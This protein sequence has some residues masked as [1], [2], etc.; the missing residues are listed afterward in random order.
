MREGLTS[1]KFNYIVLLRTK[2]MRYIKYILLLLL[3]AFPR[4]LKGEKS[5]IEKKE[6]EVEEEDT[7]E[8]ITPPSTIEKMFN[9]R[10]LLTTET[11]NQFGYDMF[12]RTIAPLAPFF[13]IA[14]E[15]VLG[16]GDQ[17]IIEISGEVNQSWNKWIGRDG[18]I[19][20]PK[21]GSIKLWGKT[22]KEAKEIIEERL[23]EEFYGI[24]VNVTLGE[25]RSVNVYV[26]GEVNKPGLYN[27]SSLSDLLSALFWAQ[28]PKKSGSL[29]RI[30]YISSKGEKLTLDLYKLLIEG[31][32][33]PE[34][35]LE[36]GDIIY[37]PP[38]G[39]VIGVTGA[40]NRPSIYEITKL[41]SVSEI[42]HVAGEMLPT[43][44]TF[45][46]QLERISKGERRV[47]EDFT[48]RDE[49][50]FKKKTE[51]IKIKNGDL[52]R[53]FEVPPYVHDYVTIEGNVEK[54][55]VYGLK[56]GMDVLELI[57]R[58]GGFLEGT[59]LKRSELLRFKGVE[60][61]EIIEID[62]E[63]LIDGDTTENIRLEEWDRL[64]IYN[65]DEIQ[66]RFTV[67]ITGEVVNPGRYPLYPNMTVDDLLFK[68]IPKRSAAQ[69]VL[70]SRIDPDGA[71]IRKTIDRDDS[72][73]CALYLEHYDEITVNKKEKYPKVGHV[74]FSGEFKRPGKYFIRDGELLVDVINIAGGFTEEAY[75]EAVVFAKKRV[76]KKQMKALLKLTQET[77]MDIISEQSRLLSADVSAEERSRLMAHFKKLLLQLDELMKLETP[78]RVVI[79]LTE[80]L[81]LNVPLGDGD[82]LFVPKKPSTVEV[83]GSVY[84]PIGIRYQEGLSLNG[85]LEIAGGAKPTA[86]TK[87]I[88]VR[89]VSGEVAK[90]PEKIKPGDTIIVPEKI[91]LEKSIWEILGIA[92]TIIYQLAIS[93]IAINSLSK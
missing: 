19:V 1:N 38:I 15:Y 47:I 6:K 93:I 20:I 87:D 71:I 55:G 89:R 31:E 80:P 37:I 16:P 5:N 66:E 24:E 18:K 23:M 51:D 91:K 83:I 86:E 11:L 75:P 27:L 76:A 57:E 81:Q 82:S 62:L 63:K 2:I 74:I 29:R 54:E 39:N 50:D 28:G 34:I 21:V 88:Y 84:N 68:G 26:L 10:Y 32:K 72:V 43:G 4:N 78:G 22:Y 25:L 49:K 53:V 64:R 8:K 9:K 7:L 58:A 30:K 60:S 17:V 92:S 3:I 42:L 52:L 35:K 48:F 13:P 69:E 33:I 56:E 73:D 46:I 36:S 85:Y 12:Q 45:R 14:E 65:I 77:R 90:D 67:Q 70:L 59:Y 44:G 41:E 40:V 61:P 79:D